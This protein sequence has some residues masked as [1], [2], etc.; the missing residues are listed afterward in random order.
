MSRKAA[1]VS[2]AS[3]CD[4]VSNNKKR[5]IVL[6]KPPE[7]YKPLRRN[8]DSCANA[9]KCKIIIFK[10]CSFITDGFSSIELDL[11]N[12]ARQGGSVPF[13]VPEGEKNSFQSVPPSRQ[14]ERAGV[15]RTLG[16][17]D[18]LKL[19]ISILTRR[20]REP[21]NHLIL[22]LAEQGSGKRWGPSGQPY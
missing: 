17:G 15:K 6:T 21:L 9:Q 22:K 4:W 16:P 14:P 13:G 10:I 19:S 11:G 12:L 8:F 3:E 1:L 2:F 7:A 18:L 5:V 20:I